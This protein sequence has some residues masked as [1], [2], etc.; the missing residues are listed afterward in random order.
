M[1]VLGGVL[2]LAPSI[3]VYCEPEATTDPQPRYTN[4]KVP[5]NSAA[6]ARH[7]SLS[8]KVFWSPNSTYTRNKSNKM[9]S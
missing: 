8:R 2:V 5:R 4:I 7:C 3:L 9:D 1:S 6:A